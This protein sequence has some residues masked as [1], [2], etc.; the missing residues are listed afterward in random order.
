MTIEGDAVWRGRRLIVE[1]DSWGAHGTQSAFELDRERDLA[2]A[3]AGWQSVRIT[4]RSLKRGIPRDLERL[5][6]Q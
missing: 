4:W 3:A 1:L 5:L 2:L 6:A